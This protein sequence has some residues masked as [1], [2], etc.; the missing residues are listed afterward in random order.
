MNDQRTKRILIGCA[1]IIVVSCICVGLILG[2]GVGAAVIWPIG[3]GKTQ[4]TPSPIQVTESS[5]DPKVTDLPDPAAE[6]PQE[7]P[8]SVTE[9]LPEDLADKLAEIESQVTQ[10]RG[11]NAREQ[12]GREL[13]SP[14]DLERIVVED[15][16]SEYTDEEA[17]KDLLILSTLGLLPDG[18]DLLDFYNRLYSEQ[19][20]GFYDDEIEKIFVVKGSDFTGSEKMTYAHEFTHVLQDQVYDL[21]EGLDLN[22]EDCEADSERCAAI[23]ALIEGDATKTELLWFQDFASQQDYLDLLKFY[24]SFETPVL[25]SA[26]VYISAD[27]YFPYEKGLTFVEYLYEQGGFDA[28]DE[29]YLNPPVSTEQIIHPERYPEDVPVTVTLPDLTATLNDGWKLLDQ[30]VMGEWYTYLILGKTHQWGDQISEEKARDAAEGWGGDAYAFY[31]NEDSDQIIFI[32]DTIWDTP[33]DAEEFVE[34]F[35]DYANER[36]TSLSITLSDARVYYGE[37]EFAG[38]WREGNRTIWVI[39]PDQD[40]VSDVLS[41]LQ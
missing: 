11:L 17:R 41:E 31:F 26:P 12:V 2:I 38:F 13:I 5:M 16:F 8:E 7:V 30:D 23:Q 32:L 24:N 39:A 21:S 22:D 4:A 37:D 6:L 15:F 20:A 34:V 9:E 27:L 19:I 25:D 35:Y 10:I 33:K 1:V 18:F 40:T 14:D 28:I 29:A 3:S 36:W